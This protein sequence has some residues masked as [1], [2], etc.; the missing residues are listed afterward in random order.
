MHFA[1][2]LYP[3]AL[4]DLLLDLTASGAKPISGRNSVGS[5][6]GAGKAEIL[7]AAVTDEEEA[8][9]LARGTLAAFR[10][11]GPA[12]PLTHREELWN[13]VRRVRAGAIEAER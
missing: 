1:T 9:L 8:G 10:L 3:N 5:Q 11:A 13:R 6:P 4:F 7:V 2:H 12:D